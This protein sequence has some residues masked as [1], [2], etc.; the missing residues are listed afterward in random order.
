MQY[1]D[2]WQET[3]F[4]LEIN[5]WHF[6]FCLKTRGWRYT[7]IMSWHSMIYRQELKTIDNSISSAT[8]GNQVPIILRKSSF[9]SHGTGDFQ[10][11]L[12]SKC[13]CQMRLEETCSWHAKSDRNKEKDI[14]RNLRF[15]E[16]SNSP[17]LVSPT[18]K[19]F[20]QQ[21]VK[22][23]TSRITW[24]MTSQRS[25]VILKHTFKATKK[26]EKDTKLNIYYHPF[27]TNDACVFFSH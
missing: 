20:V 16:E 5:F 12:V 4:T 1:K 2:T 11:F 18:N 15:K 6:C 25:V 7:W 21:E 23:I 17:K 19:I 13:G 22:G 9:N 24:K 10:Y 26:H 27:M 8:Q 3:L 14:H